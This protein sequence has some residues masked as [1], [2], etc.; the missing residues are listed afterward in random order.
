MGLR[1]PYVQ[2]KP[3]DFRKLRMMLTAGDVQCV[4]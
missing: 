1:V 2:Q 3:L 4:A